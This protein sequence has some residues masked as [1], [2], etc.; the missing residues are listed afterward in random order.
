MKDLEKIRNLVGDITPEQLVYVDC[1]VTGDIGAFMPIAGQCHYATSPEHTHPGWSFIVSFDS[2]CRTK[3]GETIYDSIPSTVFVLPPYIPHQELPSDIVSRYIA[4]MIDT[5]FLNRQ[6]ARYT[7]ST[8]DLHTAMICRS[9]QRLIDELK[10]FMTEYEEAAPGY[11]SLLDASA[12]KITH[13]LIRQLLDIK[14]TAEAIT[15]RMSVNKALEFLNEH[16][17][18][19]IS[20]NDLASAANCSVSHFFRIFKDETGLSP[21]DY[22]MQVRLDYAKRMLRV[23][24]KTVTQIALGCGFNSSSYFSHCFTRTFQISPSDF[25]KSLDIA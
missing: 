18:E 20:V 17:G 15:H 7:K 23:D 6:L 12:L 3:V 14:P 24:D 4:V 21:S 16:Y 10:E 13:L 2:Y 22:I 8:K 9:T 1:A 5:G 11:E 19:K 25:R